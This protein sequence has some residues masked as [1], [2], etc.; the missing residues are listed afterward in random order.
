MTLRKV[1]V[2]K[3]FWRDIICGIFLF[4]TLY[5]F[6]NDPY[7]KESPL[8]PGNLVCEYRI[9]P[10]GVDMIHPRLGWYLETTSTKRNLKQTAYQILVASSKELLDKGAADLWNS[11]KVHA[12]Q[13]NQ[14]AYKGKSLH[15]RQD[16]FW[17]VKV[18]DEQDKSS[19]WSATAYWMMGLLHPSEWKA[20]WIGSMEGSVKGKYVPAVVDPA[21]PKPT[22]PLPTP[23][24]LRKEFTV[25]SKIK[26]AVLYVTALGLYEVRLNG[27]KVGDHILAPEW[28]NY[29]KRVQVDALDVTRML[30][31]GS[32]A[33]GA[34]VGNGWFCGNFQF[35]P[36]RNRIFGDR[37]WFFAQLEIEMNDGKKHTIITDSTWHVTTDG[38]LRQ[39]GIYEG[40]TY[41]A[42]KDL[43]GWDKPGFQEDAWQTATIRDTI[44]GVGKLVWQRNEPIKI[45]KEFKAR[46]INKNVAGNYVYDLGQNISGWAKIKAIAPAG[47]TV[48]LKYAEALHPDG[49]LWREALWREGANI[50]A[51]DRYTFRGRG[52]EIFEPHFTYHGFRY[53]EVS[54]LPAEANII[55]LT[56]CF[57]HSD[58]QDAGDFKCSDPSL[59]RLAESIDW[60]L[61]SNFMGIPT[62]CNNRDERTGVTGD[63]Q[64]FMPT[65][66]YNRD[67]AAFFRKWLVDLCDDSQ[68][69]EGNF[70]DIAPYYGVFMQY[71]QGWGDAGIICPYYQYKAYADTQEVRDH[72]EAMKKH[73]DFIQKHSTGYIAKPVRSGTPGDWLNRGGTAPADVMG[74][75][76]Y[77]WMCGM[78]AEMADAIGKSSEAA[79]YKTLQAKIKKAF[80]DNF[81]AGDGTL[82]NSSQTGYALAFNLDLV[83]DNVREKMAAKFKQEIINY[84]YHPTVGFIGVPHL[85]P[86]LHKAGLDNEACRLLLQKGFPSWLFM[87]DTGQA[88]TIWERW[89]TWTP[90]K[91]FHPDMN[92]MN[93]VV[94][95]SVGEFLYGG[96]GGITSIAPGYKKIRIDPVTGSGISWAQTAYQSINGLIKTSWKKSA[97]AFRLDV[98]IPPNT[99]A[100]IILPVEKG[101][102]LY[103]GGKPARDVK[104]INIQISSDNKFHLHLGSGEYHF[105]SK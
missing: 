93:H 40:E 72:F 64:F 102:Q 2:K 3:Q 94:W 18:W 4:V 36:I 26:K 55:E 6:D 101:R 5:A 103:E 87:I 13:T 74:T 42:T 49:T 92:S 83:P 23:R 25:S 98:T 35:W 44:S 28:T 8:N 105:V 70:A 95:G 7:L 99:S 71:T 61:Q 21:Q 19:P 48:T 97:D 34:I 1:K 12:D 45:T 57:F 65:A 11:G 104:D 73:V 54:G 81:I 58:M 27:K 46:L 39:S 80:A 15:S 78:M 32:N 37:P 79:N 41:D 90:E 20:Y 76:Y 60:S 33:I 10:T 53:I 30:N 56:G 77:A 22:E 89:D 29:L 16:C 67:V 52:E 84:N 62:D 9:N 50:A 24:Y 75:A 43:D 68:S 66:I 88:T 69:P 82:K 100:D 86:G 91:G 96:I 17:K 85:L 59:N 51:I 14:I 38:P 63:H 47:T 31:E